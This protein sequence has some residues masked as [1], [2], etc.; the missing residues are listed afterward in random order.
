MSAHHGVLRIRELGLER[1]ALFDRHRRTEG[2]LD[3]MTGAQTFDLRLYLVRQMLVSLHHV[4]PHGVATDWRALQATQHA[5]QRRRLAPGGV[6][7]PGVLVTVDRTV[8]ILVDLDQARV[9]RVAADDR[10]IL[11]FAEASGKGRMLGASDVLV[12]QEQHPMLE[13]LDADLGEQAVVMDGVSQFDA[14]QLC[15]NAAG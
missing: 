9:I 7:V 14:N 13:Q 15:A 3:A 5:A 11:Q 8:R 2:R 10:V 12:A 1:Q 4:G 6:G